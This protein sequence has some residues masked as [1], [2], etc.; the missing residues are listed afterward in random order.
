MKL[1]SRSKW[2]LFLFFLLFT[3]IIISAKE[4]LHISDWEIAPMESVAVIPQGGWEPQKLRGSFSLDSKIAAIKTEIVISSDFQGR[5]PTLSIGRFEEGWRCYLNGSL[6]AQE[7]FLE[8]SNTPTLSTMKLALIPEGLIRWDQKNTIVIALFNDG[9]KFSIEQP[10]LDH[11]DSIYP[12]KKLSDF[13]NIYIYLAFSLMSGFIFLYY[14][15]RFLMNRND[16]AS[17]YFALANLV[18]TVYFFQMGADFPTFPHQQFYRLSKSL[19]P[20]F[21]MFLTLFFLEYFQTFNNRIVKGIVIVPGVLGCLAMLVFGTTSYAVKDFF[22]LSLLPGVIELLLMGGI[23][24]SAV[25]KGNRL[26]IPILAGVLVGIISGV[27]DASYSLQRIVPLFFTQGFGILFFDISMFMTLA[28]EGITIAK[29]LDRTSRDNLAKTEK[30]MNFLN[31]MSNASQVLAGMNRNLSSHVRKASDRTEELKV[32]NAAIAGAVENQ[33]LRIKENTDAITKVL[34]EF[35]NLQ[36]QISTQDSNIKETSA[37]TIEL[38]E[39]FDKTVDDLKRTT[40]FTENLRKSAVSA[41]SRLRDSTKIIESIQEKSRA[42]TSIIDAMN[43]IAE[44]TNLLAM[45]ASIEA[46]HAGAAGRGF[47]VVAQEIKKL[48]SNSASKAAEVFDTIDQ[49][50][51]LISSGVN[52]NESVKK[53]LSSMAEDT[54]SALDQISRIYRSTLEEKTSGSRI[55]DSMHSLMDFSTRLDELTREQEKSG[56]SVEA[57]LQNL[58]SLSEGVRDSVEKTMAGNADLAQLINNIKDVA[59]ESA[60]ESGRLNSLLTRE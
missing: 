19:L 53:A 22:N 43:D 35:E 55:I 60:E 40:D 50:S 36:F 37:V 58:V 9:G 16:R 45:N 54:E 26:A 31:E 10:F 39:S 4:P 23:S 12:Q 48:A 51:N 24:I 30:L 7:G 18:L 47:S 38:L 17:L 59:D 15:M 56:R 3:S 28:Y 6:I 44:R 33:F 25:I 34:S 21:F 32:E 13:L 49:I 5:K 27:I 20:F 29:N 52:S 57:G 1:L 11:F 42:I 41:E 46:A 14:M 2:I 8:N